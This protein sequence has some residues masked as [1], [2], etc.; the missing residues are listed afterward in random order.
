MYLK[1]I[2]YALASFINFILN[3]LPVSG[4]EQIVE[5]SA[6]L[7]NLSHAKFL[8]VSLD[9]LGD[10]V[11]ASVVPSALKAAYPGAIVDILV[12]PANIAVFQNNPLVDSLVLDEAPWW[13]EK[14]LARSLSPRYLRKMINTIRCLQKTKYDVILDLRGDLRHIFLFGAILHPKILLA[15]DKTGGERFLSCHIPYYPAI[16]EIEKKLS[17]LKPLG[18]KVD[19]PKPKIW[20]LPDEI[21]SACHAIVQWLG[22]DNSPTIL[23]DPGAKPVQQWP[24][25]RFLEV[26]RILYE[27]FQK[28][29]LVSAGPAYREL[30][31]RLANL[32][33]P[34]VAKL[35][36]TMDVRKLLTV[37]AACD[38]VISAD[39]G[40]SHIAS[41]VGTRT[42]TLFG[43]T[44]PARFWYGTKGSQIVRS[45]I[46]C[47]TSELHEKC[48]IQ[49][50]KAY[51]ACMDAIS[52]AMVE[53]AI[54]QVLEIN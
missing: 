23:I 25:E 44:D 47:C 5:D 27:R 51:G 11:M 31:E 2:K 12:R 50:Y 4:P 30:A 20:L 32:A 43:P 33:T 45:E 6:A 40:I 17:L 29:V 53:K 21:Q 34:K 13:S 52:I 3:M 19:K 8:V 1:K 15:H 46:N 39:T 54:Y 9:Q 36:P 42:L 18:I 7:R 48:R 26:V 49:G 10:A 38:L 37:V 41:A 24:V 16:S 22:V 14:P 35:M 28:P